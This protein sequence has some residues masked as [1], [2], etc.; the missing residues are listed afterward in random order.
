VTYSDESV[1]A[2][3]EQHFEPVQINTQDGTSATAALV[4]RFRQVWTPDLRVLSDGGDELHGWSG[5][6][7][8][9]EFLP[10]LLAARANALMRLARDEEAAVAYS[11]I[12]ES[13]PN[14]AVAAEASYY[15][16]IAAYRHSHDP[17]DLLG[18]WGRLPVDYPDS[19]WRV[20]QSFIEQTE[21]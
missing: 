2:A 11:T 4:A 10:K 5:Y 19:I 14:S 3:I 18:G 9:D 15:G 13:F 16:A 1:A 20:K 12:V 17:A 6:L 21:N 8:P 7:P